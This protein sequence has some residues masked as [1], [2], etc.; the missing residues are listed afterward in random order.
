[1]ITHSYFVE[2]Q[3]HPSY[4]AE[5]KKYPS[6]FAEQKKHRSY[7]RTEKTHCYKNYS[8]YCKPPAEVPGP[9]PIAAVGGAFLWSIR[10]RKRIRAANEQNQP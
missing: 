10:L 8:Y 9:L 5:Q 7:F 6:Y 2:P 1:M 4:F 3:K